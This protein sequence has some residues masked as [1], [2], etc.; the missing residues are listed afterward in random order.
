MAVQNA[1]SRQR[2]IAHA[3]IM[4]EPGREL[5]CSQPARRGKRVATA[6]VTVNGDGPVEPAVDWHEEYLRMA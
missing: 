2:N 1:K 3:S 5:D 6:S 4:M